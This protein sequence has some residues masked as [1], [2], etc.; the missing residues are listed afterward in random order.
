MMTMDEVQ[1][2]IDAE[3]AIKIRT[4]KLFTKKDDRSSEA[5]MIHLPDASSIWFVE[6]ADF[7]KTQLDFEETTKLLDDDNENKVVSG[8][9]KYS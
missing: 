2:K 6:I 1:L 8:Y 3:V 4:P 7:N 5:S 9:N